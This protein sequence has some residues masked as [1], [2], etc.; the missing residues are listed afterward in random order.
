MKTVI[1][2]NEAR[3]IWTKYLKTQYLRFHTLESG[4]IM[5]NLA[6]HFG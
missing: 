1:N 6:K 2:I 4:A 5:R 3:K